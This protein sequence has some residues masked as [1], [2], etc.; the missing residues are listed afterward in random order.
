M[1]T[2]NRKFNWL[3]ERSRCGKGTV[4]KQTGRRSDS[5]CSCKEGQRKITSAHT[6]NIINIKCLFSAFSDTNVASDNSIRLLPSTCVHSSP[7]PQQQ[8]LCIH[9]PLWALGVSVGTQVDS[10][11]RGSSSPGRAPLLDRLW[12]GASARLLPVVWP[13]GRA[14]AAACRQGLSLGP[15]GKSSVS[16]QLK[17]WGITV[18]SCD[19]CCCSHL[20]SWQSK[21]TVGGSQGCVGC[22]RLGLIFKPT[23]Q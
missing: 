18:R 8:R 7:S 14:A 6:Q 13:S 16:S 5:V 9:I 10:S 11:R 4:L 12:P 21:H 19:W 3:W 23:V 2:M 15:V 22:S 20:C 1:K 17:G